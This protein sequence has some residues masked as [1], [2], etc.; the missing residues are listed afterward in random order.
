MDEH[1]KYGGNPDVDVSFMYLTF[2]LED[3]EQLEKIRQVRVE[4]DRKKD[5]LQAIPLLVT[6]L[7]SGI[8]IMLAVSVL[9]L[10]LCGILFCFDPPSSSCLFLVNRTTPAELCSQEN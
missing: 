6:S 3:D 4:D 7:L 5:R 9:I 1:R 10:F 8:F 2:F